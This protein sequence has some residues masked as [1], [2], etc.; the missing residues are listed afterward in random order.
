M[1]K[2][3]ENPYKNKT[4]FRKIWHFLWIDES[5]MSWIVLLALS[6]SI[7]IF[8]FFPLSE[9]LLSSKLP[10][11]VIE[12]KSMVH[13]NN[14][15]EFWNRA[16]FWYE[17]RNITRE[18]FE[19]FKFKNGMGSGDIIILKGKEN[20][21]VGDVIVFSVPDDKPVIHRIVEIQKKCVEIKPAREDVSKVEYKD[22]YF[23]RTK[24][25]A[26]AG[27]LKAELNITK[28]RVFG[29]A[30]FRI[31]K[32]GYVKL[33]LCFVFPQLCSLVDGIGR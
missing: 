21:S 17:E 12:S 1:K 6:F 13:E 20:Y 22:C 31:P 3:E 32:V 7:I 8:V 26:N 2:S 33:I 27:Q 10:Y 25:D 4:L 18:T 16:G 30:V 29:K 9:S 15:D 14:F 19:N 28:E 24:G 23:I 5:L 11:V